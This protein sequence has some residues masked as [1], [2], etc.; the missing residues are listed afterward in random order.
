[1]IAAD[2]FSTREGAVLSSWN[3]HTWFQ[4]SSTIT[5]VK[6]AVPEMMLRV[7]HRKADDENPMWDEPSA[8]V[9]DVTPDQEFLLDNGDSKKAR[10]LNVGDRIQNHC[11]NGHYN[12][13][14]S[15]EPIHP[16][17]CITCEMDHHRAIV[18]RGGLVAL[19]E[20]AH[21]S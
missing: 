7:R 13:V 4:D 18:V 2:H 17:E 15:I 3:E 14:E 10:H 16:R 6:R 5:K 19:T 8:R 21:V 20:T 11:G 12:Q 1:M 9:I